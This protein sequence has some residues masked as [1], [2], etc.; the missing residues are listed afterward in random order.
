MGKIHAMDYI[1]KCTPEMIE[2]MN[3]I[4]GEFKS[5]HDKINEEIPDSREKSVTLTNLEQSAMWALKAIT[6]N[7]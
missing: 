2:K 1:K 3:K 5:L 4:R 7:Q 6:H